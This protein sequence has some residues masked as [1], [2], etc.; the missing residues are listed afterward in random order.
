MN[1][2]SIKIV[3]IL[4]SLFFSIVFFQSG[5]DKIIDRKGNLEF[6]KDHFKDT[7][8]YK[9]FSPALSILA[10][11]E[12]TTAGVCLFGFTYSLIFADTTFIFYGLLLAGLVLLMLLFGQR[13]AKDYIGAADITV[14]FIVCIITIMSFK[15]KG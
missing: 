13:V 9:I 7:L 11:L 12:I 3:Q 6:F 14:Y 5:I 1:I 10:F 15:I 2:D 8:L 4:A